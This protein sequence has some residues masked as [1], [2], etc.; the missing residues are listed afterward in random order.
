MTQLR[1]KLITFDCYGTLIDWRTGILAYLGEVLKKK[2]AGVGVE[3]FYRYWYFQQHLKH[4]SG[5]FK[6]YRDVLRDSLKEAF[7]DFGLPVE[8]DDGADFGDAMEGWE[9]FTDS[10]GAL[11]V[12]KE[13]GYALATISNS[14]HDIIEHAARKL[15]DPFDFVVTGEDVRAYKPDPRPFE[16]TLEIAGASPA[17]TL[18]VAQSQDVDLPRSVSM[19]MTTVWINRQGLTLN[20]GVPKPDHEFP[21]LAPLPGLLGLETT[22]ARDGRGPA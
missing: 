19:G 13:G 21:D 18:H 22:V 20:E 7:E 3:E 11:R 4:I 5:P 16:R 9:P 2:G 1:P 6:L 17:E 12:L 15:G 10:V 8:P 14:Q